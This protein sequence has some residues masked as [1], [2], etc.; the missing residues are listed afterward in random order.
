MKTVIAQNQLEL[1][2]G[3]SAEVAATDSFDGSIKRIS[4]AGDVKR[5]I[6][7]HYTYL[8]GYVGT[9]MEVRIAYAELI[10]LCPKS[11]RKL[12]RSMVG[13]HKNTH[14]NWIR[15]AKDF[16][17]GKLEVRTVVRRKL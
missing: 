14:Y 5:F 3:T 4:I 7:K 15:D 9:P 17:E 16:K 11:E 1:F 6:K 10:A 2:A 13:I 8:S 12:V